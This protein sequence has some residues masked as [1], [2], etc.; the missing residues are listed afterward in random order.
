MIPAAGNHSG[1]HSVKL[2]IKPEVLKVL[3][4]GVHLSSKIFG[5]SCSD[6]ELCSGMVLCVRLFFGLKGMYGLIKPE[7]S[8]KG[9][10]AG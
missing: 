1:D 3:K 2:S 9:T 7:V 10:H 8:K 4:Q 6:G 5:I